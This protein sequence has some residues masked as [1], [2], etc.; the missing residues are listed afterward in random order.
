MSFLDIA[1]KAADANLNELAELLLDRET[2]LSRQVE[3]LLKLNKTDRAL[4]KAARSQQPDLC[5]W[6]HLA[7]LAC[8]NEFCENVSGR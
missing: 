2:N 6:S 5:K 8:F 1:M 7:I 4:A 3:M